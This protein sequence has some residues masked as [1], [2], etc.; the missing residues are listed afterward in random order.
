MPEHIVNWI[1]ANSEQKKNL[2][3]IPV[4]RNRDKPYEN[5]ITHTQYGRIVK[6]PDRLTYHEY[7]IVH[8]LIDIAYMGK[9]CRLIAYMY[10]H[11]ISLDYSIRRRVMLWV[12]K[13]YCFCIS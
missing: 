1:P 3:H 6:N 2:R 10:S 9:Y 12:Y 4:H 11:L 7:I 8:T 13:S 5:T